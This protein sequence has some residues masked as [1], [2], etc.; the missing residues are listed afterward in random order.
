MRFFEIS[1]AGIR[2]MNPFSEARL[3]LVGELARALGCLQPG[4]RL[5]DLACGQGELLSRWAQRY[6]ITGTGVD[7]SQAFVEA[8]LQRA[9]ELGVASQ[10]EFIQGDVAQS[11]QNLTGYD[12]VSCLGAMDIGGS[13]AAT[14]NLMKKALK[15]GRDGLLLVGEPFWNREPNTQAALAFGI[16]PGDVL[17]LPAL[18]ELFDQAGLQLLNMVLTDEEGWDRYQTYHWARIHQWLQENPDDPDAA[19][20]RMEIEDWK[21]SY[22]IYRGHFGWGVFLLRVKE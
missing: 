4:I 11:A 19:Q 1:E 17:T 21:R 5:L 16:K 9:A 7:I 13:T 14:L 8:A 10:V 6:G 22:L 3:M 18:Y 12:V 15:D 2:I 20:F